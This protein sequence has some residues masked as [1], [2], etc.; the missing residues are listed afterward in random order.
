MSR[1][2]IVLFLLLA[3]VVGFS[4]SLDETGKIAIGDSITR[5]AYS[6]GGHASAARA[7]VEGRSQGASADEAYQRILGGAPSHP[8]VQLPPPSEES[9]PGI[10]TSASYNPPGA[11]IKAAAQPECSIS[12]SPQSV[13][14]GGGVN[15]LWK[16]QGAT[17]AELLGIGDVPLSGSETF[18]SQTAS[19]TFGLSVTGPGGSGSCYTTLTVEPQKILPG[20]VISAHPAVIHSG[21]SA[22]LAWSAQNASRAVLAHVGPISLSGGT[23]VS[24]QA[25]TRYF[26]TVYDDEGESGSCAADITVR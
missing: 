5:I 11:T 23:T 6:V 14:Y 12:V 16:T 10:Y 18:S 20:C 9:E 22:S 4:A 19:R 7:S 24:P 2:T 8:A 21:E 26:I 25:S 1:S 13:S 15:V 17:G 3:V